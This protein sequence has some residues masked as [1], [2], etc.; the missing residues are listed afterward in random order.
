MFENLDGE[1]RVTEIESLCMNCHEDA[2]G[3]TRLLLTVIPHFREVNNEIQPAASVSDFGMVQSVKVE[4]KADLNRQLVKSEYA[5]VRFDELDFEIPSTTQRG[6]LSTI[7]GIVERAIEGLS[8]EQPV[9]KVM[10]P[11]LHDK[12]VDIIA[13]LQQYMDGSQPFTVTVD[14]PSGNSYIESLCAP[15]PDPKITVKKYRRNREQ[16]EAMGFEYN[17][18]LEQAADDQLAFNEQVHSFPGICSSCFAP[19]DTKMH[20]LDIPHFKEVII[21]ATHCDACGYKSNEVKAGGAIADKGKI[22]KL[23][24]TD[25]DDMSRDILKSETCGLRIPEIDLELAPGTLGGRFTTIEGLLR[26]VYE[27]LETRSQFA[28][29]DSA[30]SSTKGRFQNFLANLDKVLKMELG[31]VTLILDD[32]L[33][34]SY[35]QNPYAPDA[36]PNMTIEIYERTWE[37]NEAYG[38]NDMKLEGYTSHDDEDAAAA[39]AASGVA[40]AIAE[41]AEEEAVND[42]DVK[43]E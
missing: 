38:I 3:T 2:S 33:A 19:S 9:R 17:E 35:V 12:I 13:T 15:N 21:M 43:D 18:E 37:Q 7:E 4:S 31:E 10:Q 1:Q 42:E 23:L 26:Q 29:G 6:V 40:D 14:D 28:A 8:Q 25:I 39:A 30:S 27:E 41:E 16:T 24:M 32:P 34:N 11:D 22:I 36:D 20:V 5:S